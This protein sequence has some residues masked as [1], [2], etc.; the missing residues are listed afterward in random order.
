VSGEKRG[1]TTLRVSASSAARELV[2]FAD[3]ETEI[4]AVPVRLRAGEVT[5]IEL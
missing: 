5:R 3:G 2:L 4:R 1:G